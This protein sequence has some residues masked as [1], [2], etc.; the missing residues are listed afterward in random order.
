MFIP[1]SI[2]DEERELEETG[3]SDD[4][5]LSMKGAVLTFVGLFILGCIVGIVQVLIILHVRSKRS[6]KQPGVCDICYPVHIV[7]FQ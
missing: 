7:M 1:A 2:L 6:G 4:V 3:N 5:T